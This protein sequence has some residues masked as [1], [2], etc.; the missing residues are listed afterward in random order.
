MTWIAILAAFFCGVAL[1]SDD[2]RRARER[3]MLL[4]WSMAHGL[5]V[6]P[7]WTNEELR[8]RVGALR[9]EECRCRDARSGGP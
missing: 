8:A 4:E 7:L 3:V 5:R 2:A 6:E 9:R 1:S